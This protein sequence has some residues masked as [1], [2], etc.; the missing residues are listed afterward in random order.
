MVWWRRN[1]SRNG[2]RRDE[3]P[4]RV[5][6]TDGGAVGVAGVDWSRGLGG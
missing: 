5:R 3:G 2:N 4:D 6:G 1:R